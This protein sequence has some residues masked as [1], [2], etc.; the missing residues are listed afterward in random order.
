MTFEPINNPLKDTI[1]VHEGGYEDTVAKADFEVF[2]KL[3]T[4]SQMEIIELR[5]W[6]SLKL[7]E[8]SEITGLPIVNEGEGAL[9]GV[10]H[11]VTTPYE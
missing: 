8:I 3:L 6:N 2:L 11:T 10:C 9:H 1:G 7:R 5:F 4:R